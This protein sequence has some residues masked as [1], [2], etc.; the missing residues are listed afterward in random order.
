MFGQ[1]RTVAES[2]IGSNQ[3]AVELE[4]DSLD[5]DEADE[6]AE[7]EAF[8]ANYT[9]VMYSKQ[10]SEEINYDKYTYSVA[11][12][13]DLSN[14]NL[15]YKKMKYIYDEIF[16]ALQWRQRHT[17]QW[18]TSMLFI[19]FLF[20]FRIFVHY[21][22][23]YC[24]LMIMQVP[25][26][27]FVPLWYRIDLV[28]ASWEIWQEFVVV[29]VGALANTLVFF[30]YILSIWLF[31]KTCKCF[32][33]LF[34]TVICWM[35]IYAILDPA[36]TLLFD[37]VSGN[38]ENGDMFKFAVYYESIYGSPAV[39]V[40]F[41]IFCIMCTTTLTCY[42]FYRW[43]VAYYMN[44]RVL[45]LYRRL[46][47]D[48]ISFFVP[49]DNEVSLK[50]LQWVILRTKRKDFV[51][52]SEKKYIK[53]KF[54]IPRAINFIQIIKIEKQILKRYRLFFKDFDGSIIEVP[55]TQTILK[56]RDLKRLARLNDK[57]HVDVYGRTERDLTALIMNTYL[58]LEQGMD[59]MLQNTEVKRDFA[60]LDDSARPLLN[61]NQIHRR[62][63]EGVGTHAI[64]ILDEQA[65]E[66]KKTKKKT[67]IGSQLPDADSDEE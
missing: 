22:G 20:F 45:D 6:E 56:K 60:E 1:S 23:Q 57:D 17:I 7:A 66:K 24:A 11:K 31:K 40:Y 12:K 30:V 55:Q 32:P 28:Y 43:M 46:S 51:V 35:G 36:L 62:G 54:G 21:M 16:L 44:G 34:E 59:A 29:C 61:V 4:P 3:N 38:T 37:L 48:Q 47:S 52:A 63:N 33:R 41:I 50:Y 26:T 5:S 67:K 18:Q 39:G 58:V 42:I 49:F 19:V 8:V 65:L 10:N 53:D 64:G 27:K 9:E 13:Y 25:V 14:R 2:A 15:T